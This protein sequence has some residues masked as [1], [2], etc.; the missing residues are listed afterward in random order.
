M[1]LEDFAFAV[2]QK[3]FYELEHTHHFAVPE[4]IQKMVIARIQ[5]QLGTIIH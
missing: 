2:A 3:V 5:E 1:K 4:A